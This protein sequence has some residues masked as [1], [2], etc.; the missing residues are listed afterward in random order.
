MV[1]EYLDGEQDQGKRVRDE[2][3][4]VDII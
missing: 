2:I 4:E 1:A 3:D